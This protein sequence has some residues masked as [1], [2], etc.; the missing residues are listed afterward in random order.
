M[1]KGSFFRSFLFGLKLQHVITLRGKHKR[2]YQHYEYVLSFK[3]SKLSNF[4]QYAAAI[5]IKIQLQR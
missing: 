5:N 4:G 3:G 2:S 1:I